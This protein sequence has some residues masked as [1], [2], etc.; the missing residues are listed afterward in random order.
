[1]FKQAGHISVRRAGDNSSVVLAH[2][3][4]PAPG[5]LYVFD[6]SG[7]YLTATQSTTQNVGTWYHQAGFASGS[8]LRQL[9]VSGTGDVATNGS[10]IAP[11]D[12]NQV[13]IGSRVNAVSNS[14][15]FVGDLT[16]MQIH[17]SIRSLTDNW[18]GYQNAMLDQVT[19][20]DSAWTWTAQ[21]S[22]LPQP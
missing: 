19:F 18:A 6:N 1:V 3:P 12:V 5:R 9:W 13:V 22:S 17:D 21:V 11:T 4:D 14:W 10:A 15:E 2:A 20:W 16:L 8:T 7:A